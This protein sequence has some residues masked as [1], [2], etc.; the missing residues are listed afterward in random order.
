M[1]TKFLSSLLSINEFTWPFFNPSP[2]EPGYVLPLQIV[3]IQ[4][5]WLLKKPADLDLHCL[6]IYCDLYQ[7]S[8]S[9]NQ[10]GRKLEMGMAS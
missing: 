4:I 5:S 3:K 7:Q 2:A 1:S 9:S 10:I 6:L 8:G